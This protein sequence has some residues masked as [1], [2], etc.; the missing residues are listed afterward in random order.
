LADGRFSG[1]D[2]RLHGRLFHNRRLGPK[3]YE[4]PETV[5]TYHRPDTVQRSHDL[6]EFV[7]SR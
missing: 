1:A 6:V 2:R 7:H 5:Q 4:T 3:M